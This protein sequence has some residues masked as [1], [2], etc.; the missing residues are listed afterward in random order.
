MR[1]RTRCVP[2]AAQSLVGDAALDAAQTRT[3]PPLGV[4]LAC[5]LAASSDELEHVRLA[6]RCS[7][8]ICGRWRRAT[9]VT[10]SPSSSSSS[11]GSRPSRRETRAEPSSLP[12]LSPPER[13]G[14]VS[15]LP[16]CQPYQSVSPRCRGSHAP[17]SRASVCRTFAYDM[18]K[19][20]CL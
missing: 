4:R 20:K 1:S 19:V 9:T 6:P 17:P 7:R 14:V 15:I 13:S 2:R 12:L 3:C 11:R 16:Y 10:T 18:G 5:H 8:A